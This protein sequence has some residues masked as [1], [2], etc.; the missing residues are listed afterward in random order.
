MNHLGDKDDIEKVSLGN[1]Y[2]EFAQLGNN[3]DGNSAKCEI[4]F[5]ILFSF[6][7]KCHCLLDFFVLLKIHASNFY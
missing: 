3:L 4:L 1:S 6:I 2:S 5:D 7:C